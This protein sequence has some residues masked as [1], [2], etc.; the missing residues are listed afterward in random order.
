MCCEL[1]HFLFDIFN[2]LNKPFPQITGFHVEGCSQTLPLGNG[3]QG[4]VGTEHSPRLSSHC[5]QTLQTY[6]KSHRLITELTMRETSWT[7]HCPRMF[8]SWWR[9]RPMPI[10]S[11]R[12]E[13]GG[14]SSW[15]W[16][17]S[18]EQGLLSSQGRLFSR[19]LI[20]GQFRILSF[21]HLVSPWGWIFHSNASLVWTHVWYVNMNAH[22]H[23]CHHP[24]D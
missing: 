14:G 7:T 17:W 18:N 6:F 10:C 5:T 23:C 11:V 22:H 20:S 13:Q 8:L 21:W 1:F 19:V 2:L 3:N 16:K 15:M 12:W 4:K 24:G 9:P